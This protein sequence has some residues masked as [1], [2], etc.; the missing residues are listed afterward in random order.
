[1]AGYIILHMY[2]HVQTLT[3]IC[4]S[5][6]VAVNSF[7]L[8]VDDLNTFCVYH[9][10]VVDTMKGVGTPIKSMEKVAMF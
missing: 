2:V 3:A 4:Q 1:M 5:S 8:S 10:I 6:S 7:K 9:S